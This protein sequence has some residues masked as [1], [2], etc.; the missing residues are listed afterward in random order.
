MG[1]SHG[2]G[3]VAPG[4]MSN[5]SKN[6]ALLTEICHNHAIQRIV[7]FGSSVFA[8]FA[9]KAFNH[10]AACLEKLYSSKLSL[11]RNFPNSIYPAATFNIGLHAVCFDHADDQNSPET[12]C[13]ITALG[14][15]NPKRGGH[16]VLFDLKLVIEFPPGSTILIPSALL[17]HG[18]LPIHGGE[19][20]QSFAQYCTGSLLRWVDYGFRTEA[21]FTSQDPCSKQ[22]FDRSIE[23]RMDA[24]LELFSVYENLL[25]DHKN[26]ADA[27]L[28]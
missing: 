22:E 24:V 13:A 9:P 16:L 28:S 2:G 7:G 6:Q 14:S 25:E 15:F 10:A 5:S 1:V 26:A 21:E 18:N 4:D 12:W 11:H 20:R 17:R 19:C 27:R 8:A 3:Q 23:E